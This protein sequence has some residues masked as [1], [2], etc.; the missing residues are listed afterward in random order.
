MNHKVTH[1]VDYSTA[2]ELLAALEGVPADAEVRVR[3]RLGTDPDGAKIK[4]VTVTFGD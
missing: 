1:K 2:A 4:R 3:T